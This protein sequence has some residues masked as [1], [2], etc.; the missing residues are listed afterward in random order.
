MTASRP[1][2]GPD[3]RPRGRLWRKLAGLL[4]F[5]LLIAVCAQ[6]AIPFYPVAITMQ[7]WAVLLAGAVLGPRWGTASVVVYIALGAA[8]LPVLANG[9]GGLAAVASAS[10]GYLIAFPAAAFIAGCAANGGALER[11]ASGLVILLA[12]HLLTLATGVGWLI[13]SVGLDPT[14]AVQIGAAPYLIGAVVK[15]VLVLAALWVWRRIPRTSV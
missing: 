13:L 9:A 15:S 10:A 12:A 8:G 7:T 1:S 14:R 2:I 11:P 3:K 6:I 4:G 5:T